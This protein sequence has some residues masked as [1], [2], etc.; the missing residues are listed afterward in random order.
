MGTM[1]IV[2]RLLPVSVPAEPVRCGALLRS[3]VAIAREKPRLRRHALNG[4]LGFAAVMAIRAI[5]AR[6]LEVQWGYGAGVAGL[7]V[8]SVWPALWQRRAPGV[9]STGAGSAEPASLLLR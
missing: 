1:A 2:A 9:L 4:G 6:H 8:W 7:L 5:Y 3:S